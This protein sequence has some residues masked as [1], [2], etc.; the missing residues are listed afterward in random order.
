MGP[1]ALAKYLRTTKVEASECNK[2]PGWGTLDQPQ[3]EHHAGSAERQGM[4]R[5]RR[6]EGSE[7]AADID[8][9]G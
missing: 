6:M 1:E 5:R 4:R 3:D 8:R 9:V 7:I 2:R